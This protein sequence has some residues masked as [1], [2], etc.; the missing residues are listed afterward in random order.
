MRNGSLLRRDRDVLRVWGKDAQSYL[1]GQ[2]SQ[3]VDALD[4]GTSAWS[5]ALEPNG[6]V[7]AWF[8]VTKWRSSEFLIDIDGGY[9]NTLS[10]RLGRFLLRSDC[11]FESLNWTM[12]TILGQSEFEMSGN[13][14]AIVLEW[15]DLVATDLLGPDLPDI[16]G[17]SAEWEKCRIA[18]GIPAMGYEINATTIPAATGLVECS[19][20]FT[21]GCYTGQEL[22]ARIDSRKGGAPTG[23]VRIRGTGS[24]PPPGAQLFVHEALHGVVTSSVEL[25]SG[26]VAL[27]YRK[28]A[29]AN[30]R[31][32]EVRWTGGSCDVELA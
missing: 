7:A 23:L 22:V 10:E 4:I 3:D 21:K 30:A 16:S 14:L 32:G 2:L 12:G 5:F 6:K 31:E 26:F 8:R 18:A 25:E 11:R 17:S 24:V 29:V 13:D 9:G 27:G 20:S 1:Q 15:P 28:R 19:V